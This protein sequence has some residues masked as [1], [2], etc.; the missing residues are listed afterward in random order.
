MKPLVILGD[1]LLDVDAEGT[2]ER[3]CPEAP[4]P[5][6]D[7]TARRRRPGG[8]GLAALL[9]A[10]SAAEVVLVTPL[11]DDEGGH[12]LT[13]LLEPDVTVAAAAAAR[14]DGVQDPGPR[15]R[16]VVG[17]PGFRR[18]HGHRRPT[19]RTGCARSWRTPAP[20]SSPTTAAA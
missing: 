2:A 17:A 15:G 8:A 20:S 13:G 10:R 4:V 14:H 7:L 9:A 6:V 11:G 16:A 1:T 18:R 5:V 19:A 3:L 12:A